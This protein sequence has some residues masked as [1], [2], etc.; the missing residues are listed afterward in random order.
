LKFDSFGKILVVHV[1]GVEQRWKQTI[2]KRASRYFHIDIRE[3]A[4]LL[5][6]RN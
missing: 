1:A 6:T 5:I 3:I 2:A 4:K